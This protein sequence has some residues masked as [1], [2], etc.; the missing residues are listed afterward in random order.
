MLKSKFE[1]AFHDYF[2]SGRVISN[3]TVN[4]HSLCSASLQMLRGDL[5]VAKGTGFFWRQPDGIALVTAWHNVSGLHH[6]SRKPLHSQG[7]LPDRI[8]YRFMTVE[9]KA[10]QELEVLLYLDDDMI[11]PRWFVHPEVGS[12]F[13]ICFIGLLPDKPE[14]FACVNDSY[15]RPEGLIL[16]GS[17]AF[18]VGFPQGIGPF[19]VFPVWKRASIATDLSIP[20]E[21]HPKFLVDAAGRAG[22]SGS[23]VYRIERNRLERVNLNKAEVELGSIHE[24]IGIY[25]GRLED[26]LMKDV[27]APTPHTR[28]R[29]SESSELGFVWREEI[30]L[31]VLSSNVLDEQPEPLKGAVTVTEFFKSHSGDSQPS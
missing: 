30:V 11:H 20:I 28:P 18:I 8:R 4:L 21:G 3:P 7:A 12:Y 1:N 24:F 14:A 9:P 22:L 10:F 13:D 5:V 16:P 31:E 19:G 15:K 27:E 25:T 17:D 29:Q 26:K 23:P 6:T 2:R